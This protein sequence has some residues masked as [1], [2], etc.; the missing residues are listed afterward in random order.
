MEEEGNEELRSGMTATRIISV[1]GKA[2]LEAR[3]YDLEISEPKLHRF[4]FVNL[5]FLW[6]RRCGESEFEFIEFL[7]EAGKGEETDRKDSCLLT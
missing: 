1:F 3:L 4:W 7:F 2:A 6:T 5:A